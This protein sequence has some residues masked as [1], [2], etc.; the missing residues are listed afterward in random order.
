ME[1]GLLGRLVVR[2]GQTVLPVPAGKQRAVL[3]VLLVR[4]GQVVPIDE[5]IELIW[6]GSPPRSAR[7]TLYNHVK[8][9]R[10]ILAGALVAPVRTSGSGYLIETG[11]GELDL[12]SFHALHTAGRMAA[13]Q[14]DWATASAQL[15][16]A[17]SLWR[18]RPL[19]DI[20]CPSL[21]DIE[22]PHLL[23]LRQAALEDRID[24][25]LH[26]GRHRAVLPELRRLAAAE[27]LRESL[28]ALLMLALYRDGRRAEALAA[29]QKAR[30]ALVSE[31]GLEPG[32]ELRQMHH[33][34]LN[35]DPALG[36]Q[37]VP[38]FP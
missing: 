1:F 22:V 18:G 28:Q 3:A 35:A 24:A 17:L 15:G 9:L 6:A 29:Y 2:C 10:Q 25:D 34:V 27:P 19:E 4:T 36:R 21:T 12:T 37:A 33:Q 32:L 14:R 31:L 30:D 38:A 23:A 26:S 5:M 16:E 8:R 20:A 13:R 11:P 7:V